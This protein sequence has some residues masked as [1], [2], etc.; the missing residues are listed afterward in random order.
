MSS[1]LE[2]G[3]AECLV[4]DAA[5]GVEVVTLEII[6]QHHHFLGGE[7]TFAAAVGGHSGDGRI[8]GT[9]DCVELPEPAAGHGAAEGLQEGA[10]L[11]SFRWPDDDHQPALAG[12]RQRVQALDQGVIDVARDVGGCGV[13]G[14]P[15]ALPES[16]AHAVEAGGLLDG[17][18]GVIDEYIVQALSLA[19]VGLDRL[20]LGSIF[21]RCAGVE[22]GLVEFDRAD[23]W[24]H[25]LRRAGFEGHA[26]HQLHH[27]GL[28]VGILRRELAPGPP[29]GHVLPVHRLESPC[30]SAPRLRFDELCHRLVGDIVVGLQRVPPFPDRLLKLFRHHVPPRKPHGRR[31]DTAQ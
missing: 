31:N 13:V 2:D 27:R 17:A 14:D 24:A 29:P 28:Q 10:G 12:P 9:V 4:V 26:V 1:P 7:R 20:R 25:T 6:D 18:V 16:L 3:A 15:G 21:E 19:G 5:G 22:P 23:P 11:A 30:A 8:Q